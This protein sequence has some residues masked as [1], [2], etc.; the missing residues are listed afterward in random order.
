MP[1][2]Y[3][4]ALLYLPDL[5]NIKALV[6][7]A[8]F[9]YEFVERDDISALCQH[10][11][12]EHS[13]GNCGGHPRPDVLVLLARHGEEIA[14]MAGCCEDCATMWQIGM[15]VLPAH[16]GRG[17]AAYLVNALALEI[18]RRGKVPYYCTSPANIPSQRTAHRAGFYPAWVASYKGL[19]EGY[20]L[21]PTS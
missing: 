17:L 13:I 9:T 12:F 8:G 11:A 21:Q 5:D 4:H 3:G 1:F 18:L 16:R 15:D 20:E 14:G 2:V 19:F 10:E 7:L 6:P